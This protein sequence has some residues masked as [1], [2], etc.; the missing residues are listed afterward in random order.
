MIDVVARQLALVAATIGM[1]FLMFAA[2]RIYERD[3]THIKSGLLGIDGVP[4]DGRWHCAVILAA[5]N[6]VAYW[7]CPTDE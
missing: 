7:A 2:G 4:T 5:P 6:G 3:V 1:L